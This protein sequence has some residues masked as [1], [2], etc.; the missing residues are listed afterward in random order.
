MD[1]TLREI[2]SVKKTSP[3]KPVL[4]DLE[5]DLKVLSG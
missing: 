3:E 4:I 2:I 5:D 1:D